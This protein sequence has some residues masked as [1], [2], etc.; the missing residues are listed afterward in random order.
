MTYPSC[1]PLWLTS[2]SRYE[3]TA[4]VSFNNA[5]LHF[6]LIGRE[7]RNKHHVKLR[8]WAF[9]FSWL[10]KWPSM[11]TAG[12][13]WCSCVCVSLYGTWCVSR[14]DS[15]TAGR[16]RALCGEAGVSV[17]LLA[18]SLS[19]SP[20][21]LPAPLQKAHRGDNHILMVIKKKKKMEFVC[22]KEI[23]HKK[24]DSGLIV[25]NKSQIIRVTNG[26]A[27]IH[28]FI[29]K[30][31]DKNTSWYFIMPPSSDIKEAGKM[32]LCNQKLLLPSIKDTQ[33][34]M[35]GTITRNVICRCKCKDSFHP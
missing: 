32:A 33:A 10:D 17:F 34:I 19:G 12:T 5:T 29:S 20:S 23:L 21:L 11:G 15:R 22:H 30:T 14:V 2:L 18:L 25:T 6:P 28:P 3:R 31:S 35:L 7:G 9:V 26:F 16:G 13:W 1:F 27:L 8:K 24:H 4:S